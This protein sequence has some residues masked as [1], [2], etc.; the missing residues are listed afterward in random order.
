MLQ[1]EVA[2]VLSM[3]LQFVLNTNKLLFVSDLSG[4]F[5]SLR[6]LFGSGSKS[7]DCN[8]VSGVY[9]MFLRQ[10]SESGS[11][12]LCDKKLLFCILFI[13]LWLAHAQ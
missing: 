3:P 2:L 10:V 4:P 13:D 1:T 6:S 9:E 12:G 5:R 7:S 8:R 11:P